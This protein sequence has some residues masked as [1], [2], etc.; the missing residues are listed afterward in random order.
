MNFERNLHLGMMQLFSELCMFLSRLSSSKLLWFN[1]RHCSILL[2]KVACVLVIVT[3]EYNMRLNSPNRVLTD[4]FVG[5]L[6]AVCGHM[7]YVD[8]TH[9]DDH[10]LIVMIH[11][12]CLL[13]WM[14][15]EESAS[16]RAHNRRHNFSTLESQL[17]Q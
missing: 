1:L 5:K 12:D 9:M 16:C 10:N 7:V 2:L 17:P 4:L 3:F 15:G 13:I 6:Y 11:N 14:L 8:L